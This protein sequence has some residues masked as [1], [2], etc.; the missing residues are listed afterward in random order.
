MEY[1]IT[2]V[3][4]VLVAASTYYFLFIHRDSPSNSLI[5]EACIAKEFLKN[6]DLCSRTRSNQHLHFTF[7]ISNPFTNSDASYHAAFRKVILETIN[8]KDDKW[9]RTKDI[10]FEA[11]NKYTNL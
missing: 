3:T 4:T 5:R 9:Q 1:V 7:G 8:F 11:V 10:A 6:S 2:I